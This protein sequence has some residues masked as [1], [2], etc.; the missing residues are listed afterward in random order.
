[1][2]S[3]YVVRDLKGNSYYHIYNSSIEGS[4]LFLDRDDYQTFLYY[5]YIYTADPAK[6]KIK[7][8]N[9]P[10]RLLARNLFND[11]F[12]VA[13]ILM[14]DHFHLLLK[15][16]NPDAMPRL[17]KQVINAYVTYF[18][19]KYKKRGTIFR[20]RYKSI[21]IESEYLLTQMVRFVHLNTPDFINY[22]WSSYIP[23]D[24]ADGL[25]ARYSSPEEREKFHLDKASYIENFP[26]I[27]DLTI[28]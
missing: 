21:R 14:P 12:M 11:I 6:L 28:D 3:K 25:K 19:K 15:Q 26:K 16:K 10:R 22:E 9:L 17:M 20:G 5:L 1:M 2:P 7:H 24:V 8:P 27:K 18:N 13:Y 23:N 4:G